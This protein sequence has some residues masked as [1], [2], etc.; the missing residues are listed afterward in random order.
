MVFLINKVNNALLNLSA[1]YTQP[2]EANFTLADSVEF[3]Y[4]NWSIVFG[5]AT[6]YLLL[7]VIGPIAMKD[8]AAWDLK[9]PLAVWNAG[10]SLFSL[11]GLFRLVTRYSSFALFDT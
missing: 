4:G 10:L 2:Y 5:I 3:T 11:V 8:S 9:M 6:V 7:V 1:I